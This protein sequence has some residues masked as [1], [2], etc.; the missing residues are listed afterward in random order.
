MRTFGRSITL[1]SWQKSNSLGAKG[2]CTGEEAETYLLAPDEE[3]DQQTLRDYRDEFSLHN[4]DYLKKITHLE[5]HC[6]SLEAKISQMEHAYREQKIIRDTEDEEIM[7]VMKE[8][9]H[10]IKDLENDNNML[11]EILSERDNSMDTHNHV[12]G[13]SCNVSSPV[14]NSAQ[15]SKR[16]RRKGAD[17]GIVSDL[18]RRLSQAQKE[19]AALRQAMVAKRE[20]IEEL[21]QST[22]SLRSELEHAQYEN[23]R[24]TRESESLRK[25]LSFLAKDEVLY[26]KSRARN[27]EPGLLQAKVDAF[28]ETNELLYGELK[29]LK[30]VVRATNAPDRD[31]NT[32]NFVEDFSES[33][34]VFKSIK[35]SVEPLQI[36]VKRVPEE[37]DTESQGKV[38]EAEASYADPS[39]MRDTSQP[40]K[41][42]P[43]TSNGH[44]AP[45]ECSSAMVSEGERMD[46]I[47]PLPSDLFAWNHTSKYDRPRPASLDEMNKYLQDMAKQIHAGKRNH[48][49]RA[50]NGTG[51]YDRLTSQVVSGGRT[52]FLNSTDEHSRWRD[53][54][55][56]GAKNDASKD[57]EGIWC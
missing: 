2:R 15:T 45:S 50:G 54:V 39:L 23:M 24:L 35:A 9:T 41:A 19:N 29:E 27:R 20:A 46:A 34:A 13:V 1:S 22:T 48:T 26:E 38:V 56:H 3:R 10:N 12:S 49:T 55:R 53:K 42:T 8:M 40:S 5:S 30:K 31:D 43:A 18:A 7:A 32:E 44:K 52:D 51:E 16:S 33:I 36:F 25:A 28:E 37:S 6:E 4:H 17:W 11:T 21:I 47:G 14:S 57:V